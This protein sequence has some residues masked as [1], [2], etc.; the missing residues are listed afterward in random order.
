MITLPEEL[1]D[2]LAANGYRWLYESG[3]WQIYSDDGRVFAGS[4]QKVR[5]WIGA[6]QASGGGRLS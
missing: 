4:V 3:V 2:D 5:T 6:D 1:E